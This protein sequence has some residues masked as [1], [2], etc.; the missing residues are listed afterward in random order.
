MKLIDELY[1][2]DVVLIPV[3][4]CLGM[5][6]R[7]AAYA[8]KNFLPTAHTFVPMHF[9]SFPVLTGTPEAYEEECKKLEL[10]ESKKIIHPKNFYGGAA[11]I[12]L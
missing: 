10:D 4:D 5:G 8:T 2:P 3:G 1:K 12:P 9:N 11:L 6:P 7:E